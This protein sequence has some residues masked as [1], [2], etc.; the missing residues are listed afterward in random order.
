[1]NVAKE[2]N[3]NDSETF[4]QEMMYHKLLSYLILAVL[5]KLASGASVKNMSD[6][7]RTLLLNLKLKIEKCGNNNNNKQT[8][9]GGNNNRTTWLG[10][11]DRK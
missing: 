1:M 11:R 3:R 2:K 9:A 4:V 10:A 6:M 8:Y 5:R 7:L